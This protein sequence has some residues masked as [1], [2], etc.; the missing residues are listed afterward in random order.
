MEQEKLYLN[1]INQININS[2]NKKQLYE[3]VKRFFN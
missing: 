3:M 2:L 1:L